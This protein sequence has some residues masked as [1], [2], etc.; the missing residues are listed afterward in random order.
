MPLV[1]GADDV[2]AK[3]MVT[4]KE[5]RDWALQEAEELERSVTAPGHKGR[6]GA[7]IR[8]QVRAAEKAV[9]ENRIE[10]QVDIALDTMNDAYTRLGLRISQLAKRAAAA[11]SGPLTSGANATEKWLAQ[12]A[13]SEVDV[14]PHRSLPGGRKMPSVRVGK[15]L[16]RRPTLPNET[17][18]NKIMRDL[19]IPYLVDLPPAEEVPVVTG[20]EDASGYS[21]GSRIRGG[22]RYK[23][24]G[25]KMAPF[26]LMSPS[27]PVSRPPSGFYPRGAPSSGPTRPASPN[28][29]VDPG[30]ILKPSAP[31]IVPGP[32]QTVTVPFTASVSAPG[33]ISVK[34][35]VDQQ[36]GIQITGAGVNNGSGTQGDSASGVAAPPTPAKR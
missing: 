10:Q 5:V 33:H 23:G 17:Q 29:P 11:Y 26:G 6:A 25:P 19:G 8:A 24:R 4:N 3:L 22:K 14:K 18:A 35:N 36:P 9:A 31:T 1:S 20:A 12:F 34:V 21:G 28:L 27:A 15:Q 2:I 13:T 30:A 32:P 7:R 16:I